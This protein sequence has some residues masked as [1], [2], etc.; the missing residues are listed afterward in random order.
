MA[1]FAMIGIG[2]ALLRRRTDRTDRRANLTLQL[3][4]YCLLVFLLWWLLTHRIDRFLIP[5]LPIAAILTGSFC[6][7][8]RSAPQ[9]WMTALLLGLNVAYACAIGL[10]LFFLFNFQ[11]LFYPADYDWFAYPWHGTTR[12]A[13]MR[14]AAWPKVPAGSRVLLVGDAQA[15]DYRPPVLYNTCFDDSVFEQLT[16]NKSATEAKAA[17]HAAKISFIYV[18]WDEL[19]RYRSPGNYGY[20]SYPTPERFDQLIADGVLRKYDPDVFEVVD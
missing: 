12:A 15:F 1:P 14:M 3:A 10:Y 20:S 4:A 8:C 2:V 6:A 5:L 13:F 18:N 9:R 17:L 19:A 7:S 11:Q 16:A